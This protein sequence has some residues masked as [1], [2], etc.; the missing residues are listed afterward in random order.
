MPI[1]DYLKPP[2]AV[3]KEDGSIEPPSS[4]SVEDVSSFFDQRSHLFLFSFG[5]RLRGHEEGWYELSPGAYKEWSNIRDFWNKVSASLEEM[6]SSIKDG[7][8]RTVSL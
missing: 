1:E 6:A 4:L 7:R 3:T 5:H 8:F 2:W